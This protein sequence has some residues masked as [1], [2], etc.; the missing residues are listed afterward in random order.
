MEIEL[1][2]P[3]CCCPFS[4]PAETPAQD[5]LDRMLDEGPW[6][7]LAQGETFEDMIRAALTCRGRILCPECGQAVSIRGRGPRRG[8]RE[9]LR[10]T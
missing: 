4:A 7:A 3:G 1:R 10:C 2:C 6:Y 5:I 8:T 9:P